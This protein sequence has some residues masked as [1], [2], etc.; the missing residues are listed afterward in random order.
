MDEL[1]AKILQRL[2]DLR[3]EIVGNIE[4]KGITASGRTQRSIT[5]QQYPGGARLVALPGKRAPIPT[6]EIGRPGGNVPGGLRITKK[7][8]LDVSNTF[9]AILVK[10]GE[11]KGLP[12]GWGEATIIGRNIAKRGTQR[13]AHPVQVYSEAVEKCA[14]D[15]RGLILAEV[16]QQIQ[17]NFE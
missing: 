8:E 10:W 14:N 7:G 1:E 12:I 16:K 15:I 11:E 3:Q 2:E 9:K 17:N 5:V 6:L 4:A 13:H